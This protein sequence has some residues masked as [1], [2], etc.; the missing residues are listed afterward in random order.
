MSKTFSD[1]LALAPRL[2][3]FILANVSTESLR[4]R[5]AIAWSLSVCS[6][7]SEKTEVYSFGDGILGILCHS[8]EAISYIKQKEAEILVPLQTTA[9]EMQLDK[10]KHIRVIV[11]EIRAENIKNMPELT[12]LTHEQIE[13]LENLEDPA[14]KRCFSK[15]LQKPG[16]RGQK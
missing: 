10:P 4:Q 15:I 13:L 9:Q 8:Q 5:W 12:P 7:I 3:Q 11:G 2:R 16:R 6:K 1:N 14:L